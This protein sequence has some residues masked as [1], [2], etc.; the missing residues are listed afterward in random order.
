[1]KSEPLSLNFYLSDEDDIA[2]FNKSYREFHKN[3]DLPLG[4]VKRP[5][6]LRNLWRAVELSKLEKATS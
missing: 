6:Y 2:L 1:M 3:K 5:V 4:T